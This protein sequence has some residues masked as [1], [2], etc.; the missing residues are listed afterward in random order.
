M[1]REG[2]W[3]LKGDSLGGGAGEE[4]D[5]GG[6]EGGEEDTSVEGGEMEEGE[7]C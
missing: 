1:A 2:R 5:D 3:E 7:D 6:D 4:A